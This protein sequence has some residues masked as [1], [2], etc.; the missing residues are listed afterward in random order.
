MTKFR[1]REYA[2]NS[3][4]KAFLVEYR[5]LFCWSSSVK[6]AF[7]T[8]DEAIAYVKEYQAKESLQ[9]RCKTYVVGND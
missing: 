8:K 2:A 6:S 1:I 3:K 5:N 7:A 4:T 9:K